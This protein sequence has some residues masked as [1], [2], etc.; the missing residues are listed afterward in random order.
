MPEFSEPRRSAGS[1]T[2][3]LRR[4]ANLWLAAGLLMLALCYFLLE[5]I[6][7]GL[8]YPQWI[9]LPFLGTIGLWRYL[10]VHLEDNRRV[11]DGELLPC[12]GLGNAISIFR[13]LELFLLA[14]FLFIPRPPGWAAWIPTLLYTSA[15][16]LDFLDGYAAR[17]RDEATKLGEE[18]EGLF[19][20]AGL[21]IATL[22]A[23]QYG[24]LSAW[25]LPFGGARYLYLLGLRIRK[26]MDLPVF[27]LTESRSRRPIAGLTMGFMSAMLWPIVRAPAS[28]LAGLIFLLPFGAS[29]LRDWFVAS[30]TIDPQSER[31]LRVQRLVRLALIDYLPVVVRTSLAVFLVS[32]AWSTLQ[33]FNSEIEAFASAGFPFPTQVVVAFLCL[34]VAAVPMLL[35]G[36]AGRFVAFVLLFPIGLTIVSLGLTELRAGLLVA[37][38]LTL[39]SGTGRFSLWEPSR[40]IFGRRAGSPR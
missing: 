9:L 13:G 17:V 5:L 28:N 24:S 30:G 36:A 33:F 6:E 1:A 11:R 27:D 40:Q 7:P 23:I 18:F 19:D 16:I 37:D 29:F 38:L 32:D 10:I 12:F 26:W 22:L 39:M 21:L 3:S 14:G 25:F 20:G 2:E 35:I 4:Q 31:Y 15:A 34:K 8:N